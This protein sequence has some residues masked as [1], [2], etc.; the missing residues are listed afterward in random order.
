MKRLLS[1]AL[2]LAM[3]LS[4]ASF[5]A[6]AAEQGYL[7]FTVESKSVDADADIT[8][9]IKV[10]GF[11]DDDDSILAFNSL[12]DLRVSFNSSHIKL[13]TGVGAYDNGTSSAAVASRPWI[14]GRLELPTRPAPSA[15]TS[16]FINLATMKEA[17]TDNIS[18]D[19]TIITLK[20]TM[21]P[22][23]EVAGSTELELS[24]G[25]VIRSDTP[26]RDLILDTEYFI[27]NGTITL[28]VD[29]PGN[30]DPTT[31]P[32]GTALTTY[33]TQTITSARASDWSIS[34]G[35][36]PPGLALTS[37]TTGSVQIS[38]T[39]TAKGTY[40]FT[41]S[42]KNNDLQAPNI[43]TQ[44][45]TITIAGVARSLNFATPTSYTIDYA[46][47]S[48]FSPFTNLATPTAGV[49]A[50][51][52]SSGNTDVATV[53]PGSGVV[54]VI[55]EGKS[56]M[57]ASISDTA[58]VNTHADANTSYDLI[59]TRDIDD[60]DTVVTLNRASYSASNL[61]TSANITSVEVDG[62]TLVLGTDYTVGTVSVVGTLGTMEIIG[63]GDVYYGTMIKEFTVT[64]GGG[65][66]LPDLTPVGPGGTTTDPEPDPEPE[67]P[68]VTVEAEVETDED[69]NDVFVVDLDKAIDEAIELAKDNPDE[70]VEI[71]IDID[72]EDGASI[73][74][75]ISV[76]DLEKIAE[77]DNIDL[78]LRNR[79]VRVKF[80]DKAIETMIEFEG[81]EEDAEFVFYV[82]DP[83]DLDVSDDVLD[84][85]GDRPVLDFHLRKGD[86]QI[87][88]MQGGTAVLSVPYDLEDGDKYIDAIVVFYI[89]E[90]GAV[91][92]A[93]GRYNP[94]T[95]T[96][97]FVVNNFN[98]QHYAVAYNPIFF[99]DVLE[100]DDEDLFKATLFL[101][102]RGITT[103]NGDVRYYEPEVGMNRAMVLT[104]IMRAYGFEDADLYGDLSGYY[105]GDV[106]GFGWANDILAFARKL[107][108]TNGTNSDRDE[109]SPGRIVEELQLQLLIE[110]SIA[111]IEGV[112]YAEPNYSATPEVDRGHAALVMYDYLT[113]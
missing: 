40:T 16:T 99:D 4:L 85:I 25:R 97:D 96:V 44:Q 73:V 10:E 61:P 86:T 57:S 51:N 113:K 107:G 90:D 83:V 69:G 35:A 7:T 50:L 18:E 82:I 81:E 66:G 112:L 59:I 43:K 27:N 31:L 2:A 110:R 79:Y 108:I 68:N 95:E 11:G 37:P 87:N 12:I 19:H 23:F 14:A 104:M 26:N 111:N 46:S 100:E 36:L 70:R 6:F 3:L 72:V 22:G 92:K 94:D 75:R 80:D 78:V 84:K 47:L 98:I 55:R 71:I 89:D 102:A 56:V 5:T 64:A 21:L 20:F 34:A 60:P 28:S 9:T 42:A 30:I 63:A 24:I 58:T 103:G 45:Y 32:G 65:A 54:S 106:D 91:R 77:N 41:V 52:Y 33:A 109:F 67:T 76:A 88:D 8:V 1:L 53:L 13:N 29:P 93:M 49:G 38:G 62:R 48:S 105:F 17:G 39:P 101:A 74:G 15:V